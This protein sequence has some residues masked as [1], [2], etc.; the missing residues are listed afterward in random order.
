MFIL[1]ISR[2]VARC[3]SPPYLLASWGWKWTSVFGASSIFFFPWVFS[4]NFPRAREPRG[5]CR[6][7]D[8]CPF[9]PFPQTPTLGHL[10]SCAKGNSSGQH[11]L[12]KSVTISFKPFPALLF[13][14][15]WDLWWFSDSFPPV[16]CFVQKEVLWKLEKSRKVFWMDA[17]VSP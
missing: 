17:Q 14:A 8:L 13:G 6:V 4:K 15:W 3:F 5:V 11:P 12:P 9:L 10:I 7:P 16:A 1:N 2:K